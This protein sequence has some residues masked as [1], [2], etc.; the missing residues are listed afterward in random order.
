MLH[1]LIN[2]IILCGNKMPK[3]TKNYVHTVDGTNMKTMF[4][5]WE[6]IYIKLY[7]VLDLLISHPSK[8]SDNYE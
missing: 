4:I 7:L 2:K 1:C 5:Y 8:S 3:F 6:L